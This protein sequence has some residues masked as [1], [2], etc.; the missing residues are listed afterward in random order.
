MAARKYADTNPNDL[1]LAILSQKSNFT[2][3]RQC[4][5]THTHVIQS[6]S[7]DA[8]SSVAGDCDGGGENGGGA[9]DELPIRIVKHNNDQ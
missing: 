7:S 4:R 2:L 1:K 6:C 9:L 5:G 3:H 8:S